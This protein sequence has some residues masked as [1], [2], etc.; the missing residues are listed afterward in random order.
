MPFAPVADTSGVSCSPHC[1]SGPAMTVFLLP[2]GGAPGCSHL[3][4]PSWAPG[5]SL[6]SSPNTVHPPGDRDHILQPGLPSPFHSTLWSSVVVNAKLTWGF[7][8]GR[9]ARAGLGVRRPPSACRLYF[10]GWESSGSYSPWTSV[11]P[12]VNGD[13]DTSLL[14]MLRRLN[15]ILLTRAQ[16]MPVNRSPCLPCLWR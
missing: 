15:R 11:S 6:P 2:A 5:C 1:G 12:P 8:S 4:L 7:T 14:R 10:P 16:E 9:E 13:T 3:S